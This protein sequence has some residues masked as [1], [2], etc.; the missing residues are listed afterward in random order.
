MLHGSVGGAHSSQPCSGI[1]RRGR[2][3]AYQLQRAIEGAD[4]N[5]HLC[6]PVLVRARV[7]PPPITPLTLPMMAS[8]LARLLSPESC[9]VCRLLPA[10]PSR[11][12]GTPASPTA[13][14][15][16]GAAR[17]FLQMFTFQ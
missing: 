4:D 5:T 10:P 16:F 9:P 14:S 2:I 13:A 6:R 3:R 17:R 8:I 7:Q 1:M 12:R 11:A 15:G